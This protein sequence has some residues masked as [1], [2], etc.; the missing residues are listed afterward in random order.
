MADAQNEIPE[1]SHDL[2]EYK[3]LTSLFQYYLSQT[4]TTLNYTFII[5]G[6]VTSYLLSGDGKHLS[7]ISVYG[8][9]LPVFICFAIGLGFL[10]AIPSSV[11]LKE[12]LEAIKGRLNLQL[13]PHVGNLT[14]TL[15]WSAILLL[16]MSAFLL[17]LFIAIK[18]GFIELGNSSPAI[19]KC[20]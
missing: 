8:I 4:I 19:V 15:R 9:L 3:Q 1:R 14:R 20:C 5:S 12:A 17:T 6:A 7:K 11:E 13:T 2:E 16:L 10:Q 18:F